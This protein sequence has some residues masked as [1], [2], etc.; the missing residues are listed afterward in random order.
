M[1]E[2]EMNWILIQDVV[3]IQGRGKVAESKLYGCFQDKEMMSIK[4]KYFICFLKK[5][6]GV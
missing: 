6:S 4:L 2:F 5:T 1:N 3:L